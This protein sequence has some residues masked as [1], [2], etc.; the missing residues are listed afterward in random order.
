M[1]VPFSLLPAATIPG[2]ADTDLVPITEYA[3][4]AP[5]TRKMTFLQVKQYLG[6][7]YYPLVAGEV[8]VTNYTYPVGNILRYGA[9]MDGVGDDAPATNAAAKAAGLSGGTVIIP[10]AVTFL[11]P[12]NL[13]TLIT[14][15]GLTIVGTGKTSVNG[16]LVTVK[17][18]GHGFD[19]TGAVDLVFN[20][21]TV[22]GDPTTTPKTGWLLARELYVPLPSGS[23]TSGRH[24]FIN[25]RSV[26]AFTNAAVY[27]YGSEEN[28][29]HSCRF[30]NTK[31]NGKV[32]ALT[33]YNTQGLS[34]TFV[35]IATGG[36]SN[37]ITN[38]F[39][40]S[41]WAAGG[42]TSDVFYLEAASGVNV[43]GAWMLAG[44]S[45]VA[46]RALCYVDSTNAS[47]DFVR[48]F[49]IH[50]EN[51]ADYQQQRF[52]VYFGGEATR[53]HVGFVLQN[54]RASCGATARTFNIGTTNASAAITSAGLFT[55][56]DVGAVLSG[57]AIG[58]SVPP[59]ARILSVT[60]ANNA[61]LTA[62]ATATNAATSV[63]LIWRLVFAAPS[64]DI[65]TATLSQNTEP[66]VRG[67]EFGNNLLNSTVDGANNLLVV[68]YQSVSNR[69]FGN[70]AN[71]TIAV[72]VNDMWLDTNT[73]AINPIGGVMVSTVQV[74]GARKN[75]VADVASAN[76]T[77]LAT[78]I[79]LANETKAQMNALLN[80]VRS[81][82]GH[83]L[84]T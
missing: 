32:L 7:G 21:I 73:G 36:Q 54:A 24:V 3:A 80:R 20:N 28:D 30:F 5:A 61:T 84:I 59:G 67:Y 45:A 41:W 23:A 63:S 58:V 53:T 79:T 69:I 64:I 17:H 77:D 56:N 35:T 44:A 26:G 47:S 16:A 39:G 57:A 68:R 49:G 62:N 78:A 1:T 15:K 51:V 10:G 52:G 25:C 4:T 19:C 14:A 50:G 48:F 9:P 72:R 29:Y 43:Y 66:S 60:D 83:G 42:A 27:S 74:V 6:P 18:T 11:T 55:A 12:V 34:S 8:G 65:D 40:G 82:T 76:A 38:I 81:G 13:T 2:V 71:W 46:G 37:L 33:G 75:A 31:V 70:S 22:A